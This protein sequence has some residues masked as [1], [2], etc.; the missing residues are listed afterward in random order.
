MIFQPLRTFPLW[1]KH[2]RKGLNVNR[3]IIYIMWNELFPELVKIGITKGSTAKDVEKRR[4]ELSCGENMP[5]PFEAKYAICVN[6]YQEVEYILHKGLDKLRYN[7]HREFFKMSVDEAIML[8][9]GFI[10]TGGATEVKINNDFL[11]EEKKVIAKTEKERGKITFRSLGI[12]VGSVLKF[13]KDESLT[14]KTANDS[15]I[16]IKPD[17]TE[18]TLNLVAKEY[19]NKVNPNNG[20]K[21]LPDGALDFTYKGRTLWELA[22]E[23][24][25]AGVEA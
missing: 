3:G 9:S 21:G 8:L 12:P 4:K 13:A 17:G 6:N 20:I 19:R 18:N 11:P 2:G 23:Q 24:R 10:A 25:R 16:V 22:L 5:Q 7:P 15:R 14:V 1:Q